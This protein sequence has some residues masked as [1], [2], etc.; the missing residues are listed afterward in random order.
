M[1]RTS[2][3]PSAGGEAQVILADAIEEFLRVIDQVHLVDGDHQVR[4]ADQVGDIGMPARLRQHA[5]A[6]VDED[7]RQVG[8]GRRRDHVARVLLVAGRVGDDVLARA[9]GEVAIG[10]VDGDALLALGLQAV[11]EQREVDGLQAALFEVRSI[12]ASASARMDL[13]S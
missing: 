9:G 12:V 4:D 1:K 11:G 7:D 2:R 6:R 5:L 13:L 3:M 8:G 10:D